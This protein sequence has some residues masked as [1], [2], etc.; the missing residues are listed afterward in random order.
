M[1]PLDMSMFDEEALPPLLDSYAPQASL[2]G[3]ACLEMDFTDWFL[4]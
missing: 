4:V 3:L 1:T 2:E